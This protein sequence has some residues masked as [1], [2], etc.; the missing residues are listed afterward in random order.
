[1]RRKIRLGNEF[2]LRTRSEAATL[3]DLKEE[4]AEEFE[5]DGDPLEQLLKDMYDTMTAA[6]GLG[7]AANQIGYTIRLFILKHNADGG[8]R[9][10]F[11]PEVTAQDELVTFENEGCLSLPGITAA[12][13]R[14]SKLSLK[15]EDKTGKINTGEFEGIMAFAVQHEMDHLNGKLYIDQFSP[16]M[17]AMLLKKHQKYLRYNGSSQ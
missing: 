15:W 8:Y 11:N 17:R 6:N 7:L 13:K 14:Y 3:A 1:M 10:Y 12:T 5:D 4:L 9:E 16:L 2:V